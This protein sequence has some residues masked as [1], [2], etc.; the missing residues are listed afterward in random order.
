M[1][2]SRRAQCSAAAGP[3]QLTQ[4]RCNTR[5]RR[6]FARRTPALRAAKAVRRRHE[7]AGSRCAQRSAALFLSHHFASAAAAGAAVA[8]QLLRSHT[9]LPEQARSVYQGSTVRSNSALNARQTERPNLELGCPYAA[10]PQLGPARRRGR[11]GF[12]RLQNGGHADAGACTAAPDCCSASCVS[13]AFRLT[14]QRGAAD[15]YTTSLRPW[16]ADM[17]LPWTSDAAPSTEP[18]SALEH[19]LWASQQ[20]PYK[21]A[22]LAAHVPLLLECYLAVERCA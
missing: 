15:L 8:E 9:L 12:F 6:R 5:V 20:T 14:A 13:P 10:E 19:V 4:P 2:S 18:W 21:A 16:L 11:C 3:L 17:H 7:R 22:A 1:L